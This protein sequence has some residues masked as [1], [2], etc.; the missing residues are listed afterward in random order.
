MTTSLFKEQKME[1]IQ[2]TTLERAIKMLG[3]L[4]VKF[5]VVADFGDG[6]G[7]QVLGNAEMVDKDFLNPSRTKKKGPDPRFARGERANHIRAHVGD[8]KVNEVGYV[9]VNGYDPTQILSQTSSWS[10]Q[11]WGTGNSTCCH[12]PDTKT[13]EILRLG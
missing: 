8:L 5:A 9:P 7:P 11:A 13:I 6:K 3:A 1:Q 2:K 10:V 12:R 4:P